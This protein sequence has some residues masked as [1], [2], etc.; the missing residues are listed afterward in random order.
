MSEFLKQFQNAA[1]VL[2][3]MVLAGAG[4]VLVWLGLFLWLGGLR[5]LKVLA[6]FAAAAAGYAV[7][8]HFA[9]QQVVI[10]IVA[11]VIAGLIGIFLEK[12]VGVIVAAALA[13]LIANVLLALPTLSEAKTWNDIPRTPNYSSD[14]PSVTESLTTLETYGRYLVDKGIQIVQ[15]L[16]NVGYT[17]GAI[18]ALAILG[19]GFAIPRGICALMC[20]ILGTVAI[21]IGL[22]LLLWYKGSK[23]VDYILES[24]GMLWIIALAMVGFGT[25]IDLAL[26]PGRPKKKSAPDDKKTG[27]KK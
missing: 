26:C 17:A 23:P 11:A 16:G 12:I 20:A 10:L 6:G 21:A 27:D 22:L 18:T 9:G 8:L 2:S 5:W 4:F 3:P 24:Q 1:F 7:A 15:G 25:L 19:I 13:A 14:A